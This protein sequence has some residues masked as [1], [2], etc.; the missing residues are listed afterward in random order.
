MRL[1]TILV[2]STVLATACGKKKDDDAVP[3]QRDKPDTQLRTASDCKFDGVK[4]IEVPLYSDRADSPKVKYRF[5]Y[6]PAKTS[7]A[8]TVIYA[9]GGPGGSS[10]GKNKAA[11][12]EDKFP[13]DFG[14]ILTDPR[15]IG[16]NSIDK[17]A[18]PTDALRTKYVAADIVEV[19]KSLNLS[20]YILF[21]ISYGTQVVTV[22]ASLAERDPAAPK[23][24]A[25]V[26]EGVLG[27]AYETVDEL[28]GTYERLW[29]EH[30]AALPA[31]SKL[32]FMIDSDLP[33]GYDASIWTGVIN[34][35][36]NFG[37]ML[38]SENKPFNF[39]AR[40]ME[41]ATSDSLDERSRAKKIIDKLA[42]DGEE[43][44]NS[45][46]TPDF[47]TY[48]ACQEIFTAPDGSILHNGKLVRNTPRLCGKKGL[49]FNGDKYNNAQWPVKAP[50]YYFEG[51]N[52]PATPLWQAEYHFTSQPAAKN[53]HM[54]VIPK[55]GHNPLELSLT[56][57]IKDIW[58]AVDQTSTLEMALKLCT[59]KDLELR[60]APAAAV[61]PTTMKINRSSGV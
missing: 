1:I 9:P 50:I 20:N 48:I 14:I 16:C 54:V 8:P 35:G 58:R 42:G 21:G 22:A 59:W 45:G 55:A 27:R 15:D 32:Q 46:G 30:L 52:D 47:Y 25:V 60:Q 51:A 28:S 40:I 10:M 38:S 7:A 36:L 37:E 44:D 12:Y 5:Q 4:T 29:D 6:I 57:C 23:P 19:I 56:D 43:D 13:A 49:S 18:I 31:E 33:L 17:G 11:D 2:T 3:V 61:S 53:K 24:K 41:F 26:L 34:L 39:L